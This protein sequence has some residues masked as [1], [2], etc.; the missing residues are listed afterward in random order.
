MSGWCRAASAV[1][2]DSPRMLLAAVKFFLGQDEAAEAGSDDEEGGEGGKEARAVN[3]TKAEVYNASKKVRHLAG[4]AHSG[5]LWRWFLPVQG[6]EG[7]P[8]AKACLS[9]FREQHCQ[10]G[11]MALAGPNT[12]G[13]L[14]RCLT[15]RLQGSQ[16]DVG[17]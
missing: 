2:H 5:C 1:F 7:Q 3:P 6:F 10:L 4:S 15:W 8:Q 13:R 9:C 12:T 17:G 14:S 11:R 16:E